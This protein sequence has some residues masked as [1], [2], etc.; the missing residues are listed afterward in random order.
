MKNLRHSSTHYIFKNRQV[1]FHQCACG[2][3]D[4]DKWYQHIL[5]CTHRLFMIV[6]LIILS[7]MFQI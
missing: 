6:S 7:Y 2:I 4:L 5:R 1:K 3:K